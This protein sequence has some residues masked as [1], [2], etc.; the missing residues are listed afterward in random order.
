VRAVKKK[1]PKKAKVA[2]EDLKPRK[3]V[4]GG[5][6]PMIRKPP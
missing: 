4:K 5:A 2:M 3:E 6:R 1:A